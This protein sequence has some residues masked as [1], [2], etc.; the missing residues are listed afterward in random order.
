MNASPSDW[1]VP[2]SR[3]RVSVV[4]PMYRT[5]AFL[6]ELWE[7][8]NACLPPDTEIVFVDD[9]CPERS[10]DLVCALPVGLDRVVVRISPNGGQH[11]AVLTGLRHTSG[12]SIAVMDAD[13]QDT[14]AALIALVA[15]HDR[16]NVDAVCAKR[17]G[18]YVEL[19]RRLT[20]KA[21]RR[22]I[23]TLSMG[24]IPIDASMFLVMTRDA[25]QRVLQLDDPFVPLVPALARTGSRIAA[26][27]VER[28]P[29][30]GGASA[31]SGR[32]RAAVAARGLLTMTPAFHALSH[33]NRKRQTQRDQTVTSERFTTIPSRFP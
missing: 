32:M 4:I 13:L 5:S 17:R 10:A 14:P 20:A 29:R 28:Q 3:P 26:L 2:A 27:P 23:W 8:L 7:E 18:R 11:A 33:V 24:R 30:A 12:T 25:A 31:Y 6:G 1:H 19:G 21:Y 9:G 16:G 22:T 15:E